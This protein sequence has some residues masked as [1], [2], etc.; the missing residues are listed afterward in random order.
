[1]RWNDETG[2]T[3]TTLD[4]PPQTLI[5][6]DTAFMVQAGYLIAPIMLSPFVQYEHLVAPDTAGTDANGNPALEPDPANPSEDRYSG[7]LSFWPYG[8]N[9]NL[10][11]LVS[12]VTRNPAPHA[13]NQLN[14]QWQLYFF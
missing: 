10:K 12:H 1:M 13:F 6:T 5:P 8:H 2:V 3:R 4:T 14:L 7:G 9:M 11:A